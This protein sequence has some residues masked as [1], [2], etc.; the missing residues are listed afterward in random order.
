MLAGMDVS[1]NP[2]SGNHK[3]MA[4]VM[5]KEERIDSLVR[6][7]GTDTIHMNKI[8]SRK[9][10]TNLIEKLTFDHTECIAFCIRLERNRI[11]EKVYKSRQMKNRY[12]NSKLLRAFHYLVW[13]ALRNYAEKF[14]HQHSCGVDEVVF[15]CD[16]D[17]RDFAKDLGW[18]HGHEGSA[19]M[20][21]DIVAWAN[22][23][24]QEPI[25]TVSLDLADSL[26]KQMIKQFKGH[27]PTSAQGQ[28][29]TNR[30]PKGF[31]YG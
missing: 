4:I 7:L 31:E 5:G 16:G 3:F 12:S 15:Q 17:C 23:H 22:A 10:K 8:Q 13:R 24:G 1:G 30:R 27:V 2:E 26:Y 20:L 11:F 29:P 25:G 28:S 6:R 18:R 14:L 19:Y 9:E 21:A